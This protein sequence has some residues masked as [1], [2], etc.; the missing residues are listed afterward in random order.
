M[1]F[2]AIGTTAKSLSLQLEIVQGQSQDQ[3]AIL[4]LTCM[5]EIVTEP[6]GIL[7]NLT[8]FRL[9]ELLVTALPIEMGGQTKASVGAESD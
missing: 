3:N 6:R 8:F 4:C 5:F 2:C 1:V 9:V 7:T